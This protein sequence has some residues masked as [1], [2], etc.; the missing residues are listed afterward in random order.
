MILALLQAY[1]ALL[2]SGAIQP[3][4]AQADAAHVLQ[5]L[6]DGL[7][8]YRPS[9]VLRVLRVLGHRP[10]A[11][12]GLYIHGKVGRGKT[13]LMDL[14]FATSAHAPKRRLHF[15]AFLA[16]A[17]AAIGAARQ[18]GQRDPMAEAARALA[19]KGM[20]LCLDEFQVNDIADAMILSRLFA[21]LFARGLV[22]V[23]TSNSAP[24]DLYRD[25]LNRQLFLPFVDLLEQHTDQ[26]ELA[27]ARDYR[28]DKL[29]GRQLYFAPLGRA[30][31]E[32]LQAAWDAMTVKSPPMRKTL[33]VA[34]RK[35][36]I[37]RSAAGT[38]WMSFADLCN[39]ALGS[40]DYRAIAANFH[41]LI[42]E[43]IPVLSP[44]QRNE[45][46]R[47]ITLIDAL[48][49]AR[50]HLIASAAVEPEALFRAGGGAE[51]FQRT[52][53]RLIEM[54]SRDYLTTPHLVN[55]PLQAASD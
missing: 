12:H 16:E 24:A 48:Y 53:S 25:G 14:F 51:A 18:T 30:A 21:Q 28:L 41:T 43:G 22:L 13:M 45:A 11:P 19:R 38:A 5:R 52:A 2:A 8:L 55:L 33:E 31:T 15:D 46:R 37:G 7:A 9:S 1:R 27:A 10:A 6:A 17:H 36:E 29:M 47:F 32:G 42:L 44:D 49:D 35:L 20:L 40:A 23:T 54:R 34:G 26:L 3:D 4:P 50:V 39:R